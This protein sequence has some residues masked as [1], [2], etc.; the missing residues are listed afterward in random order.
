MGRKKL[1]T[2]QKELHETAVA[3]R[4]FYYSDPESGYKVLTAY[5][6]CER[7]YCCRSDC[8]HCPYGYEP[9]IEDEQ[10]DQ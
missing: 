10:D 1:T 4:Q 3:K 6:L 5:F 8:R 2:E 9:D 7:G